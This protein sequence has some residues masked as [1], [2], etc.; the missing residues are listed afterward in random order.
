LDDD[1]VV[2]PD[3]LRERELDTGAIDPVIAPVVP[4][5]G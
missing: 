4:V 1:H 3:R 5:P 2:E